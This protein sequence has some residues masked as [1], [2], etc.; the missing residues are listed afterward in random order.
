TATSPQEGTSGHAEEES[1]SAPTAVNLNETLLVFPPSCGLGSEGSVTVLGN[2]SGTMSCPDGKCILYFAAQTSSH[3]I[4]PKSHLEPYVNAV[5]DACTPRPTIHLELYYREQ[6][7]SRLVVHHANEIARRKEEA[8]VTYTTMHMTEG[9]DAA[10]GEAERVFWEV[11]GGKTM[12]RDEAGVDGEGGVEFFARVGGEE[13][14]LDD[15]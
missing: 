10:A 11:V 12:D 8:G 15:F 4:S 3:L 13:E 7:P 1:D 6:E 9:A 14:G 5:L 2:G